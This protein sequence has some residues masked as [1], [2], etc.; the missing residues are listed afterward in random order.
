[1]SN[2]P[3]EIPAASVGRIVHYR[4][5]KPADAVSPMVCQAAIVTKVH[6]PWN[7]DLD[8]FAADGVPHNSVHEVRRLTSQTNRDGEPNYAGWH[9]PERVS[10]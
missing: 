3:V 10:S 4:E 5:D 9:W 7:V 8:V 6:G 2:E 1:M